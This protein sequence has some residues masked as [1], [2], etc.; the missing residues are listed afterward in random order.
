MDR[1]VYTLEPKTIPLQFILPP[2]ER[3]GARLEELM[4]VPLERYNF[5]KEL[6]YISLHE[7]RRQRDAPVDTARAASGTF[8]S[9]ALLS[10][11]S[12]SAATAAG[13]GAGTVALSKAPPSPSAKELEQ[14]F[15]RIEEMMATTRQEREVCLFY[16]ESSN[17]DVNEAVALFKNTT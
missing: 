10:A 13:S 17:W 11:G 5:E 16:L 3:G 8:A 15:K 14:R 12:G 1:A 9:D 7:D 6:E 2:P 4:H